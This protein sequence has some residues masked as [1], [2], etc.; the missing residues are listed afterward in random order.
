MFLQLSSLTAKS[1]AGSSFSRQTAQVVGTAEIVSRE[2]AAERGKAIVRSDKVSLGKNELTLPSSSE[3]VNLAAAFDPNFVAATSQLVK[4]N[5]FR[6]STRDAVGDLL[7][8]EFPK[9]NSRLDWIAVYVA[10]ICFFVGHR[11][12]GVGG[13]SLCRLPIRNV[14]T[15]DPSDN[16][17]VFGHRNKSPVPDAGSRTVTIAKKAGRPNAYW[18]YDAAT[19]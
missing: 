16:L 2:M 11:L 18:H 3:T 19:R 6:H 13:K 7:P 10:I 12:L 14:P 4:R 17:R 8:L 1:R 15:R 5:D 9:G